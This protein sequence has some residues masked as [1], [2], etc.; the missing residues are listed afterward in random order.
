MTTPAPHPVNARRRSDDSSSGLLQGTLDL[1]ILR[2]LETA[3]RH[4]YGVAKRLRE[5]SDEVILV[6]E[7]S[8]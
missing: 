2:T 8:L 7:G 3:S 6:E 5:A 1:L 4:G